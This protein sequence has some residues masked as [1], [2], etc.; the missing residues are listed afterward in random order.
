MIRLLSKTIIGEYMTTEP[1]QQE[2]QILVA[3]KIIPASADKSQI[4]Y[5]F[6]ICKRKHLDPFLKYVHMIERNERDPKKEGAWIKS[7]TIQTSLDGMRAIAQRNVKVI[8]YRRTVRKAEGEIYGCCEIATADRG[9][10]YDEVPLSE[11]I[12]KTKTGDVT[13]FWKQFPQTMIK[14]VAEESVLRMLC[15]EDLSNIYGDDEMD[16]ADNGHLAPTQEAKQIESAT[17]LEHNRSENVSGTVLDASFSDDIKE[18]PPQVQ[19]QGASF[20][21]F[22]PRTEIMN[23]GKKHNGVAW[24]EVPVSYLEWMQDVASG[25]NQVKAKATL[26]FKKQ[27]AAQIPDPLDK[28]FGK[29]GATLPSTGLTLIEQL[30]FNLEEVIRKEGTVE[31]LEGWKVVNKPDTDKLTPGEKKLLAKIFNTALKQAKEGVK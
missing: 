3:N 17:H 24:N 2:I 10:Y 11:Y 18:P 16:Q 20:N 12:G 6:E 14:K 22:D 13:K 23:F 30:Q 7:Y 27:I 29:K 31:A 8:N 28:A 25:E 15:P 9:T 26:E 21:Q 19:S 5:F 4:A 1:T